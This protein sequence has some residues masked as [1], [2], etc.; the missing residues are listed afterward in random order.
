MNEE[1]LN[2]QKREE[3][4]VEASAYTIFSNAMEL[5]NPAQRAR[6]VEQLCANAP[7][8]SARVG[9]LL[10]AH[11]EAGGFLSQP[12]KATNRGES[13]SVS[14]V[15]V[16]EKVGDVI[17]RYKL[18][19]QIGEGGCGI[20]YMAEQQEPV[21]RRVALKVIKLG[22]DTRQVVARFE[23]ERQALAM[24]DHPG[25]ARVF[26]AGST[27]SGRPFFV[28]EL[29]HGS[30]ITEFCD[31]EKL[32]TAQR[33]DLF[34][35]VCQAVQHAHQKG[36][37]HRD[38]KPSNILVAVVDG[39]VLPKVIDFGIA[40]ATSNQPL[41]DKTLF[42]AFEQ[43]IG[44]PAYVSPEQAEMSGVD[45]DTRTDIYSLGVVLYELLT[46][47]TPFEHQLLCA[48][49]D[50]VRRT[51]RE[52]QPAKPSTRLHALSPADLMTAAHQR[53]TEAPK[54]VHSVRGDLD[55]IVIKCLEKE[56]DRRYETATGL[57]RDLERYV[58]DEPVV[59]RPP[60][61]W[62]EFQ[63][64]VRR[65]KAG[66]GATAAVIVALAL[67]LGMSVWTLGKERK[68]RQRAVAAERATERQLYTAL[69][70]QA[71]A[72]VQS[73]ELG[74][75]IRALEAIR[76][77]AI[78]SNSPEL[79]REA[80]AALAQP[81]L[82]FERE[83]P[84]RPDVTF[85]FVDPMFERVAIGRGK[86]PVEIRRLRDNELITTL[87]S[88]S[89]NRSSHLATWSANGQYLAVKRDHDASGARG[90]VEVWDVPNAQ[91]LLL[92]RA[93]P[94]GCVCFHPLRPWLLVSTEEPG[95]E[96]VDMRSGDRVAHFVMAAI[97]FQLRFS[98]DGLR[99]AAACSLA[100][101]SNQS[102]SVHDALNG[103]GV[104]AKHYAPL[105][106]GV[107]WHPGGRWIAISDYR[108]G[109][110]L[111]D[112]TNGEVRV[113]GRH[114]A[115]A[116]TT[117]F[118]P[119]GRYLFSGGWER[120]LICWDLHEMQR[121]FTID[122]G[123]Y[124][125]Q[126]RS[127]GRE[128]AIRTRTGVQL[129]AIE[130]PLHREL[131]EDLGHLRRAAFSPDGRWLAASG[132]GRGAVWD[133]ARPGPAAVTKEAVDANFYF[134]SDGRQ[135]FGSSGVRWQITP[136]TDSTSPP[137]LQRLPMRK[138]K[139]FSSLCLVSNKVVLIGAKSSQILGLDELD[140]DID[141][142]VPTMGGSSRVSPDGRWLGICPSY[143]SAVFIYTLPGLARAARL[144]HPA[145]VNSFEFSPLGGEV[146]IYS[147]RRGVEFWSTATWQRT[148]VL[149][150]FNKIMI[151][152]DGHGWWLIKDFRNAA[153]Y[154]A[155]TL[156]ELL[157]L[158]VDTLPL[159]LS[160][161]GRQLAV[162]IESRRLQIWNLDELRREL[163]NL[164][165]DW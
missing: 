51:I 99:F 79:R 163:R 162:A 52:Q 94:W 30:K 3:V 38:I 58:K 60:S 95:V 14:E 25:I 29:V 115:E 135:V 28:M 32:S 63:K 159:A 55:W 149:T 125:M 124:E 155:K 23:A 40:K 106:A 158:P 114:K 6:Y 107:N 11:G 93:V 39:E 46:S 65:H 71:H 80:L 128:S 83:F 43:F 144:E 22:M 134:T 89:T 10:Q 97:P 74:Q 96:M 70:E 15:A 122:A 156:K 142:A 123:G 5:D 33:L 117:V 68:S 148:R 12:L 103:A 85:G 2:A 131:T 66:F 160:A 61:R 56:R 121:V 150:N 127:D 54:L 119:D 101:R 147:P 18:L 35:R 110:S 9:K 151:T 84:T 154:E 64:T 59:A 138:P 86:E 90:D 47:R 145:N 24:M 132:E 126:I 73:R 118:T 161:D 48:G 26:D 105:V 140:S 137:Q 8:L 112:A 143:Y 72:R 34:I 102:L 75:R 62:Y 120:E 42:T 129:H 152:P 27:A 113:L 1:S 50:E 76:R 49:I 141:G 157:P 13:E 20:V 45:I 153:L 87:P 36:I 88:S 139:A 44:T 77:A 91:R 100:D 21:R 31:R 19:E 92:L 116:V 133:L 108:G 16:T 98:A 17:G 41:T 165:L 81:D 53:Q 4:N 82:R 146:A 130:R 111:V 164:G 37:V 69:L 78:I 136:A 109:I 7:A 104:L 57:A 67:G